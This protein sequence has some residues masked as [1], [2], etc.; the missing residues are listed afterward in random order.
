MNETLSPEQQL[1]QVEQD[2]QKR[3]E[4]AAEAESE[5]ESM[6]RVVEEKIQ[7]HEPTFQ[8]SSHQPTTMTD[9]L[10]AD[11]QAKVQQWVS[12]VFTK[13]IW[14]SIKTAKDSGDMALLDAF[15]AALSGQL[16]DQLVASKQ[17]KKVA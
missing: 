10:P 8:A 11:G 16:Y 17:F 3:R 6:S 13:G 2:Y 4:A 14:R 7:Q 12:D 5:H 9:A 15:H 1:Q